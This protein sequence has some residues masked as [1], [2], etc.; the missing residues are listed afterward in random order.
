MEGKVIRL[1]NRVGVA[2]LRAWHPGREDKPIAAGMGV[3][4]VA[5]LSSEELAAWQEKLASE[6]AKP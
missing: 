4:N 2:E 1:G 6:H 3:Y 5:R